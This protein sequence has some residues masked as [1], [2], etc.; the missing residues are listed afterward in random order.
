MELKRGEALIPCTVWPGWFSHERSIK[1]NIPGIENI[2][3]F[4]DERDVFVPK[5]PTQEGGVEGHCRVYI[6]SFEEE[7]VV[8]D[9]PQ[10]SL[11]YGT[12]FMIPRNFLKGYFE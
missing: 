8:V 4:V 10:P 1:V 11:P 2:V 3:A 6:V 9:L 5:E 7:S 12:R